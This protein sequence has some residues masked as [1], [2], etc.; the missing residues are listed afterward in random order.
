MWWSWMLLACQLVLAPHR[1]EARRFVQQHW[2][3]VGG[4]PADANVLWMPLRAHWAGSQLIVFD[5]GE[6]R[7]KAFSL[8][9]RVRWTMGRMGAGPG[10]FQYVRSIEVD[11]EG[12]SLVYDAGNSRI[13]WVSRDGRVTRSLGLETQL[14]ASVIPLPGGMVVAQAPMRTPFLNILDSSGM[15]T[16]KLPIPPELRGANPIQSQGMLA[17]L[18]GDR[19]LF[20]SLVTDRFYVVEPATGVVRAYRGVEE[21]DYPVALVVTMRDEKGERIPAWRASPDLR[22]TGMGGGYDQGQLLILN[23]NAVAPKA[24]VVDA[25]DVKGGSYKYSFL[26]P[27]RCTA[28][29]INAGRYVCVQLDPAP[30]I[31]VWE[32][33]RVD[34]S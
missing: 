15:I 28:L 18:P 3:L 32:R 22:Y 2:R 20:M 7:L 29:T 5:D 23:G 14:G 31:L 9:G 27:G 11:V 21:R 12:T 24:Q 19:V 34:G 25:Y 17:Q 10:E 6:Q 4:V 30:A 1:S 26:L 8:D 13:T 33:Q 16:V